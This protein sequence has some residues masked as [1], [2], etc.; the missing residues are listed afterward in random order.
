MFKP[1]ITWGRLV[2]NLLKAASKSCWQL[3][4]MVVNTPSRPRQAGDNPNLSPQF[5]VSFAT[6]FTSMKNHRLNLLFCYFSPL[7]TAPIITNVKK[8]LRN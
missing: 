1:M 7:S 2:Y 5:T 3:S 8:G 4:T 6:S